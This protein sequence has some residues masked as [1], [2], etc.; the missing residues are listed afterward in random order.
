MSQNIQT[1]FYELRDQQNNI[2]SAE[3]VEV[4]INKPIDELKRTVYS[5]NDTSLP[6]NCRYTHLFVYPPNTTDYSPQSSASVKTKIYEL[7][8]SSHSDDSIILIA[9]PPQTN[10]TTTIHSSHSICINPVKTTRLIIYVEWL[11]GDTTVK[12]PYTLDNVKCSELYTIGEL[13][14]QFKQSFAAYIED[15][16]GRNVHWLQQREPVVRYKINDTDPYIELNDHQQ[17]LQSIFNISETNTTYKQLYIYFGTTPQNTPEKASAPYLNEISASTIPYIPRLSRV[18][19]I[20]KALH[21]HDANTEHVVM[22]YGPPGSGKSVLVK[23]LCNYAQWSGTVYYYQLDPQSQA[24]QIYDDIDI[25]NL[26]MTNDLLAPPVYIIIDEAQ[27]SYDTTDSNNPNMKYNDRLKTLIKKMTSGQQTRGQRILNKHLYVILVASYDSTSNTQPTLTAYDIMIRFDISTLLMNDNEFNSLISAYQAVKHHKHIQ[28]PAVTE[29]IKSRLG[30]HIGLISQLL[31]N[32]LGWTSSINNESDLIACILRHCAGSNA[33]VMRA[34]PTFNFS[35]IHTYNTEFITACR[36]IL[37]EVCVNNRVSSTGSEHQTYLIKSWF[38]SY[39]NQR[40]SLVFSSSIVADA[41]L[42]QF[43]Q[44]T[45][46]RRYNSLYD[47]VVQCCENM[48]HSN[49]QHSS[50][51]G[52]DSTLYESALQYEF[53]VSCYMCRGSSGL[54]VNSIPHCLRST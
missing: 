11:K 1:I 18:A 27:C 54:R 46:S 42:Q 48:N 12:L 20:L 24:K 50:S 47:Y 8:K 19:D 41:I 53:Y 2:I 32:I 10:T 40:R 29:L 31:S 34:I 49:L 23:Q 26:L 38:L 4:D 21:R 9:R 6:L 28:T 30:M 51:T 45:K 39:D 43:Y 36:N 35:T 17:T 13:I 16:V 5:A 14:T 44:P 3:S 25:D 33:R 37:R 22:L 52:V 15:T 7:F